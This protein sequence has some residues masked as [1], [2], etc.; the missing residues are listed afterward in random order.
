MTQGKGSGKGTG[1][2]AIVGMAV[3]LPG[4]ASL[5]D[6]WRNLA[7]GVESISRLDPAALKAAGEAPVTIGD[8]VSPSGR[9]SDAKGKG[10]AW[11]VDYTGALALA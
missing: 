11:A 5:D 10:E 2:I 3:N 9:K 8:V 1:E 6:F 4:A 7:G